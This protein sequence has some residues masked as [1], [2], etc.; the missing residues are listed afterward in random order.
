MKIQSQQIQGLVDGQDALAKAIERVDQKVDQVSIQLKEKN[1]KDFRLKFKT[2]T[3][4]WMK[5]SNHLSKLQKQ[6]KAEIDEKAKRLFKELSRASKT[7][8]TELEDKLEESK[9]SAAKRVPDMLALA[10]A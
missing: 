9:E 3:K 2:V 1:A 6:G 8:S 10:M 4:A 5:A 7:L